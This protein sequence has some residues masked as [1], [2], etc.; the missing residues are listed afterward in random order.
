VTSAR[1]LFAQLGYQ[2]TTLRAVADRAGVNQALIRHFYGS[3]QQLFLAA[4][5]FPQQPL[6]DVVEALEG[7]PHDE[8]GE[9]IVTIFVRAWRDP[10]TSHQLQA[11]FRAAAT[12]DEGSVMARRLLE[13]VIERQVMPLLHVEPAT[14]AAM[15][16][17]LLGYA[18]LSAIVR[19]EPLASAPEQDIVALL[20]PVVQF[21]LER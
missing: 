21:Y 2:G 7:A 9:R 17:Q 5:A 20:A 19:A 14:L 11:F 8:L 18:F 10:T 12:T 15:L 16:A 6:R 1:A 4:V 3:K 13:D